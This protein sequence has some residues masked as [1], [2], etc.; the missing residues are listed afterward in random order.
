ME[1]ISNLN[2]TDLLEVC[3]IY[4]L[5]MNWL[6]IKTLKLLLP[7]KLKMEE[8]KFYLLLHKKTHSICIKCL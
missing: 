7:I 2:L 8:V 4:Q 3:F 1:V 5:I 6:L